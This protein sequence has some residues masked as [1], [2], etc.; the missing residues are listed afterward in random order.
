MNC[1]NRS[2]LYYT[3]QRSPSDIKDLFFIMFFRILK[4][5]E[6]LR[7]VGE[8]RSTN[9]SADN[10]SAGLANDGNIDSYSNGACT[11]GEECKYINIKY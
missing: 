4:H 6:V 11:T 9:Q 10:D 8:G 7:E 2:I 5:P 3:S 1:F